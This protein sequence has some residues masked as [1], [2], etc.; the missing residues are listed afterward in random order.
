MEYKTAVLTLAILMLICACATV[1]PAPSNAV[2]IATLQSETLTPR[3]DSSLCD[4]TFS[5]GGYTSQ[6]NEICISNS[7]GWSEATLQVTGRIVGSVTER[8]RLRS[9]VGEW[10]RPIFF[11][12]HFD[13]ILVVTGAQ[14]PIVEGV[15]FEIYPLFAVGG[16]EL[17]FVPPLST[18][19]PLLLDNL[20]SVQL[21][22]LL[23]PIPPRIF[24]SK[25]ELPE[26]RLHPLLQLPYVC[27]Q[28]LDLAYCKAIFLRDFKEATRTHPRGRRDGLY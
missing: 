19:S 17:A 16:D 3:K 20:L 21:E 14:D 25:N 15:A 13:P 26:A 18:R 7:C 9:S 27:E 28:G 6:K 5:R 12:Q 22:S 23:K 24:Q 4:E 10:C 8:V 1:T 11:G 2:F